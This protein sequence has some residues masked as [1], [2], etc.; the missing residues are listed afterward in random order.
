M[1]TRTRKGVGRFSPGGA[2]REAPPL[3]GVGSVLLALLP[4]IAAAEP[5]LWRLEEGIVRPGP[6]AEDRLM[7]MG[8]LLKP[9][10]ARAWARAHPG[11]E[12]PVVR[13][14]RDS[15]CWLPSGHGGVGL[16]R[17]L[18]LSCNTYFRALAA[19]T[20]EAVLADTLGAE[21][22]AVP[23]P[24]SPEAAIGLVDDTGG[25]V[26]R[27]GAVLRAYVRLVSAPWETGEEVR[28]AVLAGL[29]ESAL[30][31]TASGIGRRGFRA[32]TGT[33]PALD[34]RPLATSGWVV[35][36]DD[37]GWAVLALLPRG[38]GREAARALAAPLARLRP[39]STPHTHT[40][41]TARTAD[42]R[43]RVGLLEALRPREVVARN[44][45]RAPAASSRGFVGPD[46]RIALEP[47]DRLDE[48]LWELSLPGRR[49][50]RHVQ[51][52]VVVEGGPDGELRLRARMS[53]PEYVAGVLAAEFPEG[54]PERRVALGAA[55]LRFLEAGPRHGT[56][57]VCDQTH[58]AWFVGRGPRVSWPTPRTPVLL[59]R[60]PGTEVPI[61]DGPTWSRIERESR[62]E[63]PRFFTGHCGGAPLSAHAVWGGGD[64]RVWRCDRHGPQ[65]RA[66]WARDW[67]DRALGRA[68]GAAVAD[69]VVD[70]SDGVWRLRARTVEGERGLSYDQVH[71][72]LAPVL[73]WDALPSPADRVR[74]VSGGFRAEGRGRGHR[75]G[76]CLGREAESE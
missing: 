6:R 63:G 24:V 38:T 47:G 46:A 68:F 72:L 55:I 43:V 13:C 73:G 21:G 11:A 9:F 37:S 74:R 14:E 42:A 31:G 57:D 23:R 7:P 54:D 50:H 48:S 59:A 56:T 70:Q 67:T 8:S 64:R 29:R 12:P 65:D 39:G 71:R 45:G 22:F 44:V 58:C 69:L 35:A 41:G 60:G 52:A 76:L 49:F 53:R 32:K 15:G 5:V 62:R 36:V 1:A 25:V 4:A 51:A 10:V 3:I 27:P 20:P 34:G 40:T 26:A 18:S 28:G 16:V 61:L 17:G 66:S 33:V 30:T 19:D 2:S 75:V